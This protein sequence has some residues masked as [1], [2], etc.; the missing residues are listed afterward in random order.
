MAHPVIEDIRALR[1][2][3]WRNPRRK[4]VAQ[5]L[6]RLDVRREDVA[7]AA[8]RLERWAPVLAHL[9]PELE[10]TGG[11]I[12]SSLR[13]LPEIPRLPGVP[14]GT[15]LKCDNELPVAGSIKARGGFHEVLAVAERIAGPPGGSSG[16][17]PWDPRCVEGYSLAV[18]STGNLGLS[19]GIL[20][21]A[22]GFRVTVH[23]SAD[24]RQWKKNLLRARGVEVVEHA[25]DYGLAVDEGRRRA[26]EDP[27]CHFVDDE[28]SWE[29]FLGYAV[30]GERTARQLAE[31]NIPVDADHPLDVF[32]PCGVGGGPGGVAFGLMLALGDAVHCWFVEPTHAPAMIL[33]LAT[34]RHGAVSAADLGIDGRTVADGL[35]VVRPSHLAGTLLENLVAG[36]CTVSDNEM[37]AAV[38]AVYQATGIPLEPSGAAGFPGVARVAPPSRALVWATGGSMVPREEFVQWIGG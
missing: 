22:L 26:A 11:I 14:G 20:G 17:L 1:E 18:G 35:A 3:V 37:V 36:G 24:A 9:F 12:E 6:P 38:A 32:L 5:V 23:M 25:G 13:E 31:R 29:L 28:N 33:G 34:G 4:P 8:A 21:S 27:R 2:T 15:L 30:A 19:I 7:A 10:A 16:T